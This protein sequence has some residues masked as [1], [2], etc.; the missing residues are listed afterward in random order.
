MSRASSRG[1][2]RSTMSAYKQPAKNRNVDETLFG[3]GGARKGGRN[4]VSGNALQRM[5]GL[6]AAGSTVLTSSEI[7]RMRKNAAGADAG[8]QKRLKEARVAKQRERDSL[9]LARKEAMLMAQ[10]E[11]KKKAPKSESQL[12]KIAVNNATLSKAQEVMDNQLDDVKA[13]NAMMAYSKVATI[14]DAQLAEKQ[15]IKEMD[16]QEERRLDAI[17][18]I[19]R[20]AVIQEVAVRELARKAASFEASRTVVSK[21]IA[22]REEQRELALE[23]KEIEGQLMLARI[24]RLDA[25]DVKVA[26]RKAVEAKALLATVTASNAASLQ[27]KKQAKEDELTEMKQ[28]EEY[29]TQ[30]YAREAAF[31]EEQ[32]AIAAEKEA[33]FWRQYQVLKKGSDGR[34]EEDERKQRRAEEA[35]EKRHRMAEL[36][37]AEKQANFRAQMAVA[38]DVQLREKE[39]K[40]ANVAA[41]EKMAY[42]RILAEQQVVID[43]EQVVIAVKRE[44]NVAAS[45]E[46]RDQ[47][48]RNEVERRLQRAELLNEGSK[49]KGQVQAEKEKVEWIKKKKVAELRAMGVPDKYL[50]EIESYQVTVGSVAKM[51]IT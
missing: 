7:E 29:M 34:A 24:A 46:L 16:R 47:I 8:A 20:Q 3:N 50:S 19:E 25:E 32:D 9:A 11:L 38:R 31:R 27:M 21:Q 36:A 49:L 43:K 37:E 14:R 15:E 10:Q 18:E 22:D 17:M 41:T 4:A 28:I 23:Q 33:E 51:T 48:K 35:T 30:K 6:D 13:M 1:S 45:D 12:K 26:Q 42:Q 40:L 39:R 2:Q 5:L 44:R